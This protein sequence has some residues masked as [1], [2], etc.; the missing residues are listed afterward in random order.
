MEAQPASPCGDS[1]PA[2]AKRA[3]IIERYGVSRSSSASSANGMHLV[4][5]L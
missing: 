4:R 3:A 5:R 1:S 2:A